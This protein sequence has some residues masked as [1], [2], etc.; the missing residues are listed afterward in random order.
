MQFKKRLMV[1]GIVS[2]ATLVVSIFLPIVPCRTAPSVP[3]PIYKWG[4]C[5]LNPDQ[6]SGIGHIIE[7]LGTTTSLRDAYVLTLL[8][9]FLLAMVILHYT[10]RTKTKK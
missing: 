4:L 6:I 1:S 8:L 7:Y 10:T 2:A 5:S 9:T 3:N